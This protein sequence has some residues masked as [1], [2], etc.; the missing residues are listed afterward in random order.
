MDV[1]KIEYDIIDT[2]SFRSKNIG[3]ILSLNASESKSTYPGVPTMH[4]LY[5]TWNP[6]YQRVGSKWFTILKIY[7]TIW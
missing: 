4:P 7:R 1:S 5:T 2:V 6:F 3:I